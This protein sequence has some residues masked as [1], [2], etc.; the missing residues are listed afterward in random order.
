MWEFSCGMQTLELQHVISSSLTRG[1]P[2]FP[3]LGVLARGPPGKSP[4]S[5][6]LEIDEVAIKIK[7]RRISTFRKIK[8]TYFP[9]LLPLNPGRI[10]HK[11]LKSREKK[12]RDF[13][14]LRMA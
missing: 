10:K 7:L 3:V 13:G 14:S 2:R 8:W 9:L 4:S 11:T 12:S 1:D 6:I 5:F